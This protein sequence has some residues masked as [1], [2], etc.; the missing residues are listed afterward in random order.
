[1]AESKRVNERNFYQPWDQL[2][3]V[4]HLTHTHNMEFTKV[5]WNIYAWEMLCSA[6][7]MTTNVQNKLVCIHFSLFE[8]SGNEEL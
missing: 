8:H 3:S 4:K 7:R 1:M 6:A 5:Y 2:L